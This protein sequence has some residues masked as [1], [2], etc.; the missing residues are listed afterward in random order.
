VA[1]PS[2]QH[3]Q[4]TSQLRKI[5][6]DLSQLSQLSQLSKIQE[7]LTQLKRVDIRECTCIIG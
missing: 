3:E 7:D 4:I 1:G 6:G 2:D 5:Q